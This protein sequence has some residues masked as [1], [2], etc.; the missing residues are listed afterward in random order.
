MGNRLNWNTLLS[1]QRLRHLLSN[2]SS[3]KVL[4]ESRS[5]YERDR[6]RTVYSSPIRRLIRKTQVF[7]LDPS[8]FIRTRLMHSVE[9][10]T[11]AEGLTTQAVRDVIKK[12]E[13]LSS[14]QLEAIPKIAETGGLLHDL[15]NP[16]FG[17]AGELAI[18][19]W[20]DS[21]DI[22]KTIISG[23]GGEQ[24]QKAQDFL[25]FEGN[26]QTLRIVTNTHLLAHSHGLNLTSATICSLRKYLAPS[27]LADKESKQHEMMKPGYFWSEEELLEKVSKS[28]GTEGCRHPIAFLVEAADDIVYSVVDLEDAVKKGFLRSEDLIKELNERCGGSSV[29]EKAIERTGVQMKNAPTALV[30]SEYSQAFRVNAISEMVR[31]VVE[32]FES[33]YD[34]I[35]NGSYHGE[36][37]YDKDCRG[38]TFVAACKNLLRD[39]VFCNEEVLRLEVKG[40]Q[41]IHDL[42][43]LFWEGA[44]SY[45]NDRKA[46]TKTYGGKLY[47]LISG[48]YRELF[49][50]RLEAGED[51]TYCAVQLVTDY[52]AGMT[53]GFAC[54]L[55][56]DLMN[57]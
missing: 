41:V 32:I 9:V 26:A 51:K 25:K 33:R 13:D 21:T 10:S 29:L 35:M 49:Q 19:S 23:L 11:V 48:N 53:D 44:Q 14:E 54:K 43:R 15:G 46:H 39:R 27:H 37:I 50:Q 28:T 24:K 42:M 57:G 18:A 47:L 7:P 8:D 31:A 55:H 16:P 17:H 30:E 56:Q 6:D 12:K 4:G 36:L 1:D 52:I 45:V 20:F 40:R 3:V 34:E 38:G 5:E 2:V 22:G